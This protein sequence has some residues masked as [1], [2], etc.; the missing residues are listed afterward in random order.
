M[1][2]HFY[3]PEMEA[4]KPYFGRESGIN[5]PEK[6]YAFLLGVLFGKLLDVQAARGVNAGAN[7]LTWLRRLTLKGKDL[8]RLYIRTREKLLAYD[9]EKSQKVREVL[10]EIG[11]LGIQLGDPIALSETQTNYY[12]LLGQSMSKTIFKKDDN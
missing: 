6:A 2:D 5:S 12:L 4:L 8:P 3:E 1:D 9:T 7:A 10:I 11:R